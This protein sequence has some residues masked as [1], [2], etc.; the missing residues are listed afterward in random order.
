VI[1]GAIAVALLSSGAGLGIGWTVTHRDAT[2]AKDR[3]A[4]VQDDLAGMT[5]LQQAC[6][7]TADDAQ[8]VYRRWD[9]IQHGELQWQAAKPGSPAERRIEARLDRLYAALDGQVQAAKAASDSC[10][11]SESL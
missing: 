4:H 1:I 10:L 6:A 2:A 7:E 5:A 3:L 8:D 9:E 11:T